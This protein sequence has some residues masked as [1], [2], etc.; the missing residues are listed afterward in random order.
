MVF[1]WLF[2]KFQKWRTLIIYNKY[3]FWFFDNHGYISKP[4]IW[5][6]DD[7]NHQLWYPAWYSV[8]VLC[9]F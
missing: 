9:S 7:H 3:V 2:E 6:F 5:L 1:R 4:S 8:R